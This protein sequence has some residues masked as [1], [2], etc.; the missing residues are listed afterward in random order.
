MKSKKKKIVIGSVVLVLLL[1]IFATVMADTIVATVAPDKYVLLSMLEM[2]K[3][4]DKE[5]TVFSIIHPDNKE[6]NLSLNL[7][8]IDGI[9][10]DY[11]KD[12]IEGSGISVSV[13]NIQDQEL[14]V[15]A[16]YSKNGT[17]LMDL[18]FYN[19]KDKIGIKI[20]TLL[21]QYVTVN[22]R[23]FKQQYD[24]SNLSFYMGN[25]EQDNVDLFNNYMNQIRRS[26]HG[27]LPENNGALSSDIQELL[28]QL[29]KSSNVRY[30]GKTKAMINNKSKSA[31]QF[32]ITIDSAD[33]K[34]FVR[35]ATKSIIRNTD[36]INIIHTYDD[37]YSQNEIEELFFEA[38]S[39]V[40]FSDLEIICTI[41]NKRRIVASDISTSIGVDGEKIKVGLEQNKT[42]SDK[43]TK[44]SQDIAIKATAD[45][46]R[47]FSST[48]NV[49]QDLKATE[50]NFSVSSK[51]VID[52][53]SNFNFKLS[54]DLLTS[55][56]KDEISLNARKIDFQL[57]DYGDVVRILGSGSFRIKDLKDQTLSISDEQQLDLFSM[58]ISEML[59][60]A[61]RI[62]SQFYDLGNIIS[63]F[64]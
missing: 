35:D 38:L 7:K 58:G 23:D 48:T 60:I 43:D 21:N 15:D 39:E 64:N 62:G 34:D 52:E 20:P 49:W 40:K 57:E 18:S 5:N 56:A 28:I 47:L 24:N 37:Y 55:K 6:T 9:Y 11:P 17:N 12:I 44:I 31:K 25:I 27:K 3:L 51:V 30:S 54:G 32:A 46:E 42:Y 10:D 13:S 22:L 36:L 8:E 16:A 14:M 59:D 4:A 63:Y 1:S 53:D 50:D 2:K 61:G 45:N 29:A 33:V 26:V 19:S 41:D